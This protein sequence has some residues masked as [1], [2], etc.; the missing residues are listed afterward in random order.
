MFTDVKAGVARSRQT[1]QFIAMP[2][3]GYRVGQRAAVAS[4][5][6]GQPLGCDFAS[7]AGRYALR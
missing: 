7:F 3:G 5:A 1:Q 4:A 6:R 2:A